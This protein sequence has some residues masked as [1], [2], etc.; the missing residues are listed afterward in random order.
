MAIARLTR[1]NFHLLAR[2]LTHM[3]RV[4]EINQL[5]QFP[6]YVIETA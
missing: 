4:V 1:G 2:L 3:Q 6:I 5:S